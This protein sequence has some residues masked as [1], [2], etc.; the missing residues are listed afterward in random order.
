[1]IEVQSR[2]VTEMLEIGKQHP[3]G[4]VAIVSHGEVIRCAVA[5]FAGIPLD[6]SLRLQI[7]AASVS[8]VELDEWGPRVA[9]LNAT[10]KLW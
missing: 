9:R 8:I 7:D 1:M 3:S 6:L 2:I 10:A 4:T 5:H